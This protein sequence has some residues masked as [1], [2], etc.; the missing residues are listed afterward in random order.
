MP[1]IEK[2]IQ[3]TDAESQMARALS[4]RLAKHLGSRRKLRGQVVAEGGEAEEPLTL[5]ASAVRILVDIL[6]QLGHG[7]TFT[8]IPINAELTTQQ[9]AGLLGVSRPFVVGLLEKG[10]IPHRV[11]GTHR[12]IRVADLMGYK[13]RMEAK[14]EKALEEL[15]A[16]DQELGLGPER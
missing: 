1:T 16:L 11:V 8:M 7:G 5:P 15:S 3:P 9:A 4:Q 10:E 12:R 2:S 6:T 14:A 13:Q